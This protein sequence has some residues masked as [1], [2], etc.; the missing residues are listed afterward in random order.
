MNC[1]RTLSI[2]CFCSRLVMSAIASDVAA[3]RAMATLLTWSWAH[4][5]E[6][7]SAAIS[8]RTGTSSL[9]RS[10][11]LKVKSSL[12]IWC[13][14][15]GMNHLLQAWIPPAWLSEK[16]EQVE[17]GQRGLASVVQDRK[18]QIMENGTRSLRAR[19]LN[20]ATVQRGLKRSRAFGQ[21]ISSQLGHKLG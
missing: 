21:M 18:S 16:Q 19:N 12:R 7:A 14:P 17:L 5:P 2:F 9:K 20:K 6:R 11:N 15:E 13:T 1:R 10:R 3:S 4:T 8:S